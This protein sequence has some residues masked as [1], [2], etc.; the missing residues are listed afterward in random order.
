MLC[1]LLGNGSCL[2][3]FEILAPPTMGSPD[4]E[5][6]EYFYTLEPGYVKF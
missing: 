4:L 5:H 6:T 1:D 3:A 2:T